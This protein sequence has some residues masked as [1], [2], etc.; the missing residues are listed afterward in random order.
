[1]LIYL[2]EAQELL[3]LDRWIALEL[4]Q[5]ALIFYKRVVDRI[6]ARIDHNCQYW[7]TIGLLKS[8]HEVPNDCVYVHGA[9]IYDLPPPRYDVLYEFLVELHH[10]E[11]LET[12]SL[13]HLVFENLRNWGVCRIKQRIE[14]GFYFYL[15]DLS[16]FL[17]VFLPLQGCLD[18]VADKDRT[19]QVELRV[20]RVG[21]NNAVVN[22]SFLARLDDDITIYLN[23]TAWH[24]VR[25]SRKEDLIEVVIE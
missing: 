5:H 9:V 25:I 1:M 21:L 13:G 15:Q 6:K 14:V 8:P 16:D 22:T 18:H 17:G 12:D 3:N 2:V 19:L 20:I 10:I 23:W 4:D 24:N 7:I 11:G